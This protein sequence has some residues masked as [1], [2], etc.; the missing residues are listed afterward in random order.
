MKKIPSVLM[1][2]CL[3]AV[4]AACGHQKMYHD[5][6]LQ[7]PKNFNAHFPD[8]DSDGDDLVS[9][10]EFKSYFPDADKN[11]FKALD[12]NGDASVDHEEW[13]AFKAAH[14]LEHYE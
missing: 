7:D 9:W 8:L 5:M 1:V 4:V 11:V 14:K 10:A 13:H 3:V 12:L 6:E 2:I